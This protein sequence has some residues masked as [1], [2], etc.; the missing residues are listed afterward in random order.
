MRRALDLILASAAR[1]PDHGRLRPWRF[2][3]IASAR[4]ER[5]SASCSRRTWAHPP[6][7]E[8]RIAGARAPEGVPRAADRGGRRALPHRR[9]RSR[10]SSSCCRPVPR[11]T[12]SC[13]R[14]SRSASTQCGRP[15]GRLRRHRKG[16][17]RPRRRTM[18]S[19]ASCTSG[20]E[21][22]PSA[23]A[24]ARMARAGAPLP[25]RLDGARAS[26]LSRQTEACRIICAEV[27]CPRRSALP[28]DSP[29]A[30][31]LKAAP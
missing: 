24:R 23:P 28:Y 29:L 17:A 26:G 4:R 3:V 25:V 5:V 14:R 20:S 18:P 11:R 30:A 19:S 12:P 16:G 7:L 8:C 10:R 27:A 2:I 22:E 9:S 15:G 31:S 21:Q 1:A 6:D 13:W